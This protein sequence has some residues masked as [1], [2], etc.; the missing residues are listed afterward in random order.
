M[1]TAKVLRLVDGDPIRKRGI[2]ILMDWD[3]DDVKKRLVHDEGIT[4]EEAGALEAEY[5][6]FIAII[7][8]NPGPRFPISKQVDPFWHAHLMFTRDYAEMCSKVN[9]GV[10]IHHQPMTEKQDAV[11]VRANYFSSTLP[12]Y[13]RMFGDPNPKYWPTVGFVHCSFKC[14]D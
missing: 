6:R 10:F 1:N 4:W 14:S 12:E 11:E 5:K 8:A 7:I 3:M 13:Q 9:N 2:S